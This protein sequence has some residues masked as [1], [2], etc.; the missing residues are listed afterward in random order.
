MTPVA[1]AYP[2]FNPR[3][4]SSLGTFSVTGGTA[5][6]LGVLRTAELRATTANAAAVNDPDREQMVDELIEWLESDDSLDWDA[7]ARARRHGW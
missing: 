5:D 1:T 2:P 6:L 3:D 7:V 4:E